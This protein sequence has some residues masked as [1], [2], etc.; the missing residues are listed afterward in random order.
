MSRRGKWL[1][2][3]LQL[4]CIVVL[5]VSC[6]QLFSTIRQYYLAQKAYSNV[7][8][9]FVVTGPAD[10][11]DNQPQKPDAPTE[12]PLDLAP[13]QV[14]FD[15]LQ[16]ENPDVVGWIYCP[17]TP[18]NYP[19]MQGE[20]ND[21]Y[22]HT[23]LDGTYNP[24]GS[25]FMDYR[26]DGDFLNFN[27]ILYGHN[28]KDG[29]MFAMLKEYADEAYFEAHPVMYLLTPNGDY[30][31][32]I[33]AAELTDANSSL[34]SFAPTREAFDAFLEKAMENSDL[35]LSVDTKKIDKTVLLSTCSYE[36]HNAR[37]IVIGELEP[38][39]QY[40]ESGNAKTVH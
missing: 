25:I 40:P 14:D 37:Y 17:D 20:T 18:V 21:T 6:Y 28:M 2:R 7:S 34:Y 32:N 19:V 12:P 4:V 22:L 26:C 29:S 5:C 1:I 15:A 36:F 8:D 35:N 24:S 13:I 39:D 30:R 38:L 9:R 16:Q 33:I 11:G 27:T 23:M 31:V 10:K 3:I